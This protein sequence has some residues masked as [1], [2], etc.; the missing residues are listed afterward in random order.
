MQPEIHA[1]YHPAFF[2]TGKNADFSNI[3]GKKTVQ[4]RIAERTGAAGDEKRFIFK[5]CRLA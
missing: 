3:G 1:A 4:D 2:V 5:H